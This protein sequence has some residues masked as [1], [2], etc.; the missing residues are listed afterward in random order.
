MHF[1]PTRVLTV[2][3]CPS[4]I[5]DKT[6]MIKMLA[7]DWLE[8]DAGMKQ[9]VQEITIGHDCDMLVKRQREIERLQHFERQDHDIRTAHGWKRDGRELPEIIAAE[10]IKEKRT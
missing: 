6:A 9:L 1:A 5:R 2:A 4:T 8:L 3:I 7:E 10:F